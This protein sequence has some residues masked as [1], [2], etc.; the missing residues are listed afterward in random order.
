VLAEG[1]PQLHKVANIFEILGAALFIN[2]NI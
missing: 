1:M 2:K